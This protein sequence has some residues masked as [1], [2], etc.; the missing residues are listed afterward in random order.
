MNNE[1]KKIDSNLEESLTNLRISDGHRLGY[2]LPASS[3][4]GNLRRLSLEKIY[5]ENIYVEPSKLEGVLSSLA[6]SR[7]ES[8]KI[9][10]I[11]TNRE[12]ENYHWRGYNLSTIAEV[13]AHNLTELENIHFELEE[14]EVGRE[15][16][17]GSLADI[18]SLKVLRVSTYLIPVPEAMQTG[19]F[20]DLPA[21][22]ES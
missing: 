7:L 6:C 9:C 10:G 3:G 8:L 1:F 20:E 11:R 2:I 13:V 12:E 18:T 16:R 21:S 4:L 22:L 14:A 17:L 5:V 15:M 19:L